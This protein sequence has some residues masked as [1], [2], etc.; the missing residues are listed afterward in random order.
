MESSRERGDC[1][2]FSRCRGPGGSQKAKMP[3]ASRSQPTGVSP[4]SLWGKSYE[5]LRGQQWEIA[6][7]TGW[8][9]S[10]RLGLGSLSDRRAKENQDGCLKDNQLL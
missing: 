7:P 4:R 10:R 9:W 6:I 5:R 2:E 3:R 1:L 8:Q